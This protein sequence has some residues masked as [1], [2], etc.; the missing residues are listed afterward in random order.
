MGRNRENNILVGGSRYLVHYG[1]RR[2][3]PQGPMR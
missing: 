1:R 2:W 3:P